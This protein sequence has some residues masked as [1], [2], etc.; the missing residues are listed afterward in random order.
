LSAT[1]TRRR[2]SPLGVAAVVV[3]ALLL[4]VL[5]VRHFVVAPFQVPTAS[6]QPTLEPGDVILADRT[7]RGTAAL[8]QVVV[9]D[10]SGYFPEAADGSSF[11]VKRVIGVSGDRV[12]CCTEDGLVERNGEP[13]TEPYLS[14]D[15][16]S[17]TVSFDVEVPEGR[18]FVLGDNRTDSTDSRSLL[19]A[20]GGGMIPVNR[21]AGEASRIVWPL[22][23]SGPLT[24]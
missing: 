1:V 17:A 2:R 7:S 4:A 10:G 15:T 5:G 23:R 21:V 8:G 16:D 13:L 11:V 12:R 3:L 24:R 18:I 22:P 6:M 20:P 14:P 9:I 19:G